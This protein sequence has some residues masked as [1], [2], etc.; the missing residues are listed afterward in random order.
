MTLFLDRPA[1]DEWIRAYVVPVGRIETVH[2][3]PWGTVLRLRDA[4]LEPWGQDLGK[5]FPLAFRV[6]TFARAIAYVRQRA[7]LSP[8]ERAA[9][10]TDFSTVLRRAIAQMG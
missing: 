8:D 3:R 6:G 10:D 5:A 4:Y 7:A 2:E 1:V 9:F